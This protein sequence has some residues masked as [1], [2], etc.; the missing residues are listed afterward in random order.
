M[1]CASSRLPNN[2]TASDQFYRLGY[3]E[4]RVAQNFYELGQGDA[5]KRL[6]WAQRRAQ[7]PGAGDRSQGASLQKKYVNVTV[8]A[9]TDPDGTEIEA[10]NRVVE[11][12][13][14]WNSVPRHGRTLHIVK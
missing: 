6:W 1:G 11:I 4:K 9:H 13:Q 2:Q 14:F 12:V 10:A 3:S 5:V 7:E 8:P